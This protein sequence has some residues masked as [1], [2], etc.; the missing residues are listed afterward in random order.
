MGNLHLDA[1]PGMAWSSEQDLDPTLPFD[2]DFNFPKKTRELDF[3]HG[4]ALN[5]AASN[6]YPPYQQVSIS[7]TGP[8]FQAIPSQVYDFRQFHTDSPVIGMKQD[9]KETSASQLDKLDSLA[10]WNVRFGEHQ[11]GVSQA[12]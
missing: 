5:S 4:A 10:K 8:P 7:Q 1:G 12:E 11:V 3:Q 2:H 9:G 6:V